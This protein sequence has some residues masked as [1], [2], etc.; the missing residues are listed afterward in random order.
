VQ[1]AGERLQVAAHTGV[2][3]AVRG[4]WLDQHG[5]LFLDSDA[6]F[7]IVHSQDMLD[8]AR[9][10]EQGLWTPE[11]LAFEQMPQRFGYV[12]AP[13]PPAASPH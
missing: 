10:I 7:G 4:A 1:W 3:A 12:L 6:G 8:A 9:A 13:Q 5:H 2:E 11:T